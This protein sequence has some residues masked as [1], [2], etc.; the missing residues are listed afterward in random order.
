MPLFTVDWTAL[1]HPENH[2]FSTDKFLITNNKMHAPLTFYCHKLQPEHGIVSGCVIY[3]LKY[4]F[5]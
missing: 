1:C 4:S 5:T 2:K 3:N